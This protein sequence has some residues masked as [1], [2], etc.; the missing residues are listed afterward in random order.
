MI[1]LDHDLSVDKSI[2]GVKI[3]GIKYQVNW[4]KP[5]RSKGLVLRGCQYCSTRTARTRRYKNNKRS[6][7]KKNETK[8]TK[9][10][11]NTPQ[12]VFNNPAKSCSMLS[13]PEWTSLVADRDD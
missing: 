13:H 9:T 10:K 11:K 3:P 8:Q 1:Y 4:I 6:R 7:R 12:R 5:Q 2:E